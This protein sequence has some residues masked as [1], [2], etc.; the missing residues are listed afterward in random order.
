MR[1]TSFKV[2]CSQLGLGATRRKFPPN[3][4]KRHLTALL[5]SA[6]FERVDGGIV[7]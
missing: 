7:E 2:D 3:F 6:M 1:K 4:F 5:L